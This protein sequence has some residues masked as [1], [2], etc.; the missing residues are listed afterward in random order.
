MDE[1]LLA[2]YSSTVAVCA[3]ANFAANAVGKV[4]LPENVG[5]ELG[6]KAEAVQV[7]VRVLRTEKARLE[8]VLERF[9]ADGERGIVSVFNGRVGWL[10]K[11]VSRMKVRWTAPQTSQLR[12]VVAAEDV[13]VPEKGES[14]VTCM[15]PMTRLE[16]YE[17]LVDAERWL[18]GTLPEDEPFLEM[19]AS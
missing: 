13:S 11:P 8:P 7:T 17:T 1:D 4:L 10:P 16:D 6:V 18:S 15:M 5:R 14:L 19:R 12:E 2:G 9:K 3:A